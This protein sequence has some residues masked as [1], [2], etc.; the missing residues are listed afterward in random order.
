MKVI[1][2]AVLALSLAGCGGGAGATNA[3]PSA[4]ANSEIPDG[5]LRELYDTAKAANESEVVLYGPPGAYSD[6]FFDIF[7][8][9][10]PGITVRME[11]IWGADLQSRVDA[12][13]SQKKPTADL[14]FPSAPDFGQLRAKGYLEPFL[15][16]TAKGLGDEFTEDQW[17]TPALLIYGPIYNK[18]QVAGD[19]IPDSW[20]DI[21]SER[22][23][24]H[25]GT[26]NPMVTGSG[27]QNL[28]VGLRE[29]VIDEDWVRREAAM[30]PL[31][32]P[33]QSAATQ[34]V[35]NGQIQLA[36]QVSYASYLLASGDGA[37]VGFGI[38][39]EG[40]YAGHTPIGL[41]KDAPHPSAAKLL[42]SWLYSTDGQAALAGF[43][44]QGTMPD[45]PKVPNL[46]G[47][48]LLIYPDGEHLKEL[49]GY[50]KNLTKLWN[51]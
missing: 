31:I 36:V 41:A 2:A 11:P 40:Q 18:S 45:A 20:A 10:F 17:N 39:K 8:K 19:D 32:F 13:Y 5:P 21:V 6:K 51:E 43:G 4:T 25:L 33:S 38:L 12:D 42:M 48:K 3:G 34:A 46:E 1:A 7:E 49:D 44:L 9:Q 23:N 24:G 15:P 30:K 50:M 29:S 27:A 22:F 37:P 28:Q 35:A 26:S 14:F 16:E 47:I